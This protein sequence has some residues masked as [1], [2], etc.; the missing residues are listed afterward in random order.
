MWR[1]AILRVSVRVAAALFLNIDFSLKSIRTNGKCT[2]LIPTVWIHSHGRFIKSLPIKE[3]TIIMNMTSYKAE[4]TKAH[5]V[6]FFDWGKRSVLMLPPSFWLFVCFP[7]FDLFRATALRCIRKLQKLEESLG[8]CHYSFSLSYIFLWFEL[9]FSPAHGVHPLLN[10]ATP[11]LSRRTEK[12][13]PSNNRRRRWF[14]WSA[15]T[16]LIWHVL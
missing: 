14:I 5:R 7:C 16:D 9:P 6:N 8:S 15:L 2:P 4:V 13:S 3:K 1:H 12:V 11:G 10:S